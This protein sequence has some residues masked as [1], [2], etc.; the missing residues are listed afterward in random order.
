MNDI[1][2]PGSKVVRST[3]NS[4]AWQTGSTSV[5][6]PLETSAKLK[7]IAS[8]RIDKRRSEGDDTVNLRGVSKRSDEILRTR[9]TLNVEGREAGQISTEKRRRATKAS[10]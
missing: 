3:S 2:W 4:F 10:I 9:K 6:A 5:F 7:A 8:A 1:Y